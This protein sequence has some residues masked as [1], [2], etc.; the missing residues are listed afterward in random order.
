MGIL[1]MADSSFLVV[2]KNNH[3]IRRIVH[4]TVTTVAGSSVPGFQDGPALQAKFHVLQVQPEFTDESLVSN[5]PYL[6]A[7]QKHFG[8]RHQ[9][10][11]H[12]RNFLW[13]N[14]QYINFNK[15]YKKLELL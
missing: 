11:Q 10:F 4:N 12:T 13:Y 14:T 1:K 8:N 7:F 3:R 2:D 5:L 15:I 9:E 6:F